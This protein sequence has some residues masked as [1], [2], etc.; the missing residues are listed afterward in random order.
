MITKE[1]LARAMSY[2]QYSDLLDKLLE[3]GMTTGAIQTPEYL[4]YAKLN[5][6]RMKRLDK[7]VV[8]LPQL[9][10]ALQKLTTNLSWLVLTEGWCGD[11]AQNLP[12]LAAVENASQHIHLG[13]L[14]RDE[15]TDLIDRY[16]T[17]TARAIP[18]LI[19]VESST[20]RE[21]FTWG[22]RPKEAQELML[23]L[24]AL[25]VSK[26]EKSLQIQKWYIADNTK[27]LQNELAQLILKTN[28]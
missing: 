8:L 15:N 13:L 16:L 1:E 26:E 24:K 12:V 3:R 19:C 6:A 4:N 2:Q 18:K 21:V 17:G 25:N 9:T 27:T 22:P 11:A 23:E 10:E 14:L 20:L 5:R 28:L 7:S